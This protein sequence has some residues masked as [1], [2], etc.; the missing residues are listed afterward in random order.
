MII[1]LAVRQADPKFLSSLGPIAAFLWVLTW[2]GV[3]RSVFDLKFSVHSAWY[4]AA[5]FLKSSKSFWSYS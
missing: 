3:S 1:F 2:S 4:S 5:V